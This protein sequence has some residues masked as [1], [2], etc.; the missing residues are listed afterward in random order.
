[1]TRVL[2]FISFLLASASIALAQDQ[3]D[4]LRMIADRIEIAPDGDLIASGDI[5]IFYGAENLIAE[6]IRY[7][8]ETET[9]NVTGSILYTDENGDTIEAEF[10]ELS[11]DLQN[12]LLKSARI[13]LENQLELQAAEMERIDGIT[14][15]LRGV[16]ATSCISCDTRPPFGRSGQVPCVMI[17]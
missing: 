7:D 6:D 1:M 9:L 12:G 10:A 17:N 11:R 15:E 2:I 3:G 13:M 4:P 8:T 16:A 5:E 14:A